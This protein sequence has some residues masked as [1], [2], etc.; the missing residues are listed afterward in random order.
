MLTVRVAVNAAK[1]DDEGR[2]HGHE[3]VRLVS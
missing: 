2:E 1:V 3:V